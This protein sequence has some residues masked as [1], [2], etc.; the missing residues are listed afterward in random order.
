MTSL[1]GCSG[2]DFASILRSLGYVAERRN[3]PPITVALIPLAAREP[4]KTA[5]LESKARSSAQEA[6][7][8]ATA[9]APAEAQPGAEVREDG[10]PDRSGAA[11]LPDAAGPL[12][13][14]LSPTMPDSEPS[15]GAAE[16][17]AAPLL[18][19][20]EA[21]SGGEAAAPI[22]IEVWRA[23]R[24]PQSGNR[25]T[26]RRNRQKPNAPQAPVQTAPE[27]NPLQEQAL[28]KGSPP[29]TSEARLPRHRQARRPAGPRDDA[30]GHADRAKRSGGHPGRDPRKED[31]YFAS[32]AR[33]ARE[34]SVDPDS[35]F[36]KLLAL[37]AE[38]ESKPKK[39]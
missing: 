26:V 24:H 4:V 38:L 15:V 10:T 30:A 7:I 13:P 23:H 39:E 6:E 8:D 11:L 16:P 27:A 5:A 35:P 12:A 37:K 33:A 20:V 34:R 36:A 19:S 14:H 9:E 25:R 2:E 21:S 29:P 32:T 1:A 22:V 28:G 31:R 18:P 17:S 3:G